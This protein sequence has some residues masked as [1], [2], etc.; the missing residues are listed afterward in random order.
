MFARTSLYDTKYAR[1]EQIKDWKPKTFKLINWLRYLSQRAHRFLLKR[2][3][4]QKNKD[5]LLNFER[6]WTKSEKHIFFD[7][8]WSLEAQANRI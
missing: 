6:E 3:Q 7:K 2:S 8:S 5:S 4:I 1:A